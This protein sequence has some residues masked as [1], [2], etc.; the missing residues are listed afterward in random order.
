MPNRREPIPNEPM[1]ILRDHPHTVAESVYVARI[2]A[3]IT[4]DQLGIRIGGCHSQVSHWEHGRSWLS[5]V[6]WLEVMRACGFEVIVRQSHAY[7]APRSARGCA[8]L[9][10]TT[11]GK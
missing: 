11:K 5:A 1:V 6:R 2:A 8:N 4:Q 9:E 10:M 3:G 7:S